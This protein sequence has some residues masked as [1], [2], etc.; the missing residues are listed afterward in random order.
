MHS[1]SSLKKPLATLHTDTGHGTIL[2]K[3]SKIVMITYVSITPAGPVLCTIADFW[4]AGFSI[5]AHLCCQC[6]GLEGESS[7]G[8]RSPSI[9]Q[10]GQSRRTAIMVQPGEYTTR[11]RILA[12]GYKGPLSWYKAAMHG[13]NDVDETAISQED[14]FCKVPTLLIVSDEDYVT[15][16]EVQVMKCKE[17]CP[18]LRIESLLGCGHWI[19]LERPEELHRLLEGFS[20]EVTSSVPKK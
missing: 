3:L 14:R 1:T 5:H 10:R 11:D 15:R 17:W 6:K 16:A 8:W 18:D 19:Q 13:V 20:A 12:S 7:S 2:K 9:C 4:L